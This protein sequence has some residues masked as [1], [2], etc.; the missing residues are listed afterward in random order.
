MNKT[1]IMQAIEKI[2]AEIKRKSSAALK[3]ENTSYYVSGLENAKSF[4]SLATEKQ[5][6]IE[7]FNAGTKARYIKAAKEMGLETLPEGVET[8]EQYYNQTYGQ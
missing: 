3:D 1:A 7:T 2:D 4:L 6:H 5:Q 8:G